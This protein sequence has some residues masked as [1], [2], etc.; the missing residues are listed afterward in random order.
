MGN[1]IANLFFLFVVKLA[2]SRKIHRRR[3]G[4]A[5]FFFIVCEQ[6]I[7]VSLLT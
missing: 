4:S 6:S 2:A 5:S 1:D 3:G 7:N